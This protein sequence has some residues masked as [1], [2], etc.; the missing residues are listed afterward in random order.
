M[1]KKSKTEKKQIETVAIDAMAVD[2]VR[3]AGLLGIAPGTLENMRYAN[4]GPRYARI[5]RKIVYPVAEIQRYLD[6]CTIPSGFRKGV[7]A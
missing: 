7:D 1:S 3:A 5:G 2:T 4:E 6:E